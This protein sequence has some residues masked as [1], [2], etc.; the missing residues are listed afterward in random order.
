MVKPEKIAFDMET[1]KSFSMINFDN[2]PYSQRGATIIGAALK[3]RFKE[4]R[5]RFILDLTSSMCFNN[6]YKLLGELE[7]NIRYYCFVLFGFFYFK[8]VRKTCCE[9]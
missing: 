8:V 3:M 6:A 4:P 2:T 7:K 1:K 9:R 5:G